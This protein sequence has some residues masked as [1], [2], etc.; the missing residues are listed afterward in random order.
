[1]VLAAMSAMLG[2]NQDHVQIHAFCFPMGKLV[3][4]ASVWRG[5][6]SNITSLH[7]LVT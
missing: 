5:S 7:A 2:T 4:V 6:I 3:V 1:M